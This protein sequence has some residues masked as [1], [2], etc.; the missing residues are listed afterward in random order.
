[1]A[2]ASNENNVKDACP[3]LSMD[4]SAGSKSDLNYETYRAKVMKLSR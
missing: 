2:Y 3:G 4:F 1:M